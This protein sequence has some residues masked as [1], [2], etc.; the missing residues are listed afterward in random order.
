MLIARR[1]LALA[2]SLTA[3]T[4]AA[5]EPLPTPAGDFALK[6]TLRDGGSLDLMRLGDRMRVEM[7]PKAS[8][9]MVVGLLDLK[10]AKM[11]LMVPSMPKMAVQMELPP[12]YNF[13]SLKGSGV[14]TGTSEVAGEPCD[15]WKIDATASSHGTG[16]TLA[17]ITE[18]GIAL[19]TE[20]DIQGKQQVI[21]EVTSVTRGPQ[22]PRQFMV[23]PGVQTV[24]LPKSAVAA[25][26]G[27]APFVSGLGQ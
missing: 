17:C 15:L 14:R 5:A 23:P 13:A 19:R 8:P 7:L 18:D 20:M 1:L 2:L 24:K 25:M 10:A 6:A 21:Y 3:V 4:A 16:P 9:A 26:P 22:D 11:V 27:L 12:E